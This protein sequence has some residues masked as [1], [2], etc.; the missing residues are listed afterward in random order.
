V[1]SATLQDDPEIVVDEG[2]VTSPGDHGAKRRF[3]RVQTASRQV[4][5]TLRKPRRQR[6]RQLLWDRTGRRQQEQR[7][8]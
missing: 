4:G 5:D 6:R 7:Q 3:G 8:C 1:P 2:A